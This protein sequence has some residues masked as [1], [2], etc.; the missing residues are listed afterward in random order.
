MAFTITPYKRK[1]SA[2]ANLRHRTGLPPKKNRG[3]LIVDAANA[4]ATVETKRENPLHKPAPSS[5]FT[6]KAPTNSPET[7]SSEGTRYKPVTPAA[8]LNHALLNTYAK[9]IT[10]R[11]PPAYFRPNSLQGL[12]NLGN[13]CYLNAVLQVLSSL[14][15]FV[16]D[17]LD[18]ELAD[19]TVSPDNVYNALLSAFQA[20]RQTSASRASDNAA[21]RG[22]HDA[23]VAQAASPAKLKRAVEANRRRFRG[24]EQQDAH[25]FLCSLL[26]LLQ[27]E[28]A[29]A[30][31]ERK[32][33]G[34]I[35]GQTPHDKCVT[36]GA[37]QLS[38]PAPTHALPP[39]SN[40]RPISI[41]PVRR[42]FNFVMEHELMC[43][44]CGH[45]SKVLEPYS[46]LS[47]DLPQVREGATAAV[48][49]K[50]LL[51]S[52]FQ[53]EVIEHTCDECGESSCTVTHT[54]KRL[55]RVLLLHLKRFTCTLPASTPPGAGGMLRPVW[56]KQ[57]SRVSFPKVFTPAFTHPEVRLPPRCAEPSCSS[58]VLSPSGV[59]LRDHSCIT[60]KASPLLKV[61]VTP[62][63]PAASV[64]STPSRDGGARD[65]SG[66][67]ME[68]LAAVS[69][70]EK[71]L[72]SAIKASMEQSPSL[73]PNSIIEIDGPDEEDEQIRLA[74][75]ASME[76]AARHAECPPSTA[77]QGHASEEEDLER[78][79]AMSLAEAEATSGRFLD[80]QGDDI[81]GE[82]E[83][84]PEE[85]GT[86]GA[87]CAP[88]LLEDLDELEDS[89]HVD[90]IS[91]A[92]RHARRASAAYHLHSVVS[93][94]GQHITS[95]HYIADV[96][97]DKSGQWVQYNDS[98][99]TRV[100]G[101]QVFTEKKEQDAYMLIYVLK[102]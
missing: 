81:L 6:S 90:A 9:S 41:C 23:S 29:S 13:T 89:E 59:E 46:H 48:D 18:A 27:E 76:E 95:G 69:Q 39:T 8:R 83:G 25:E 100:R 30:C 35:Q 12:A 78:A 54:L 67:R 4:G 77:A 56:T 49:L 15:P 53:D 65:K 62:A 3:S 36:P 74:L 28:V 71:D 11:Q 58:P 31:A 32:S 98:V 63:A 60:P 73:A 85:A 86:G 61:P 64:L 94:L 20:K 50:S 43:L 2:I 99:V 93:H 38:R 80:A 17:L 40:S 21:S 7:P 68:C 84:R 33:A 51:T 101:D 97:D 19:A 88:D 96:Y 26:E 16:Q 87:A 92:S 55:P 72:Q 47:L 37:T 14:E 82:E 44:A 57:C 5:M 66:A 22:P 10:P 75:Q 102:D 24:A 1:N 34:D 91:S 79:I 70:E 45:T 42:N 52:Y